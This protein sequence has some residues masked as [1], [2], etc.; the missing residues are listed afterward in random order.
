LQG[1]ANY[2]QSYG[3]GG[4]ATFNTHDGFLEAVI[5][6][7]RKGLLT[8]TDMGVLTQCDSL[9]DLKVYLNNSTDYG[10]SF[11]QNEPSPIHTTTIAEHATRRLVEDFEYLRKNAVEPLSTFLDYITY[12]YM[13][14]NVVLLIS[15]TLHDRDT[16]ELIDKCHPLGRFEA[17]ETITV[18][19]SVAELYRL[20]IIETPL[21]PYFKDT[22]REE[23]LDE[24]NVEIIRNTLY[25]SYLED[26]YLFCQRLG[27]VTGE[28]MCELLKFEADRRSITITIN[29]LGTELNAA[30]RQKLYP[31]FGLL[32]PEGVAALEKAE[33][34]DHVVAA[35]QHVQVYRDLLSSLS[36]QG[37]SRLDAA[38][39]EHEV[40]LNRLAFMEQ[41][42][43]GVF[44]AFV[45]LR[46]QEIRNLVWVAECISQDHRE[47]IGQFIPIF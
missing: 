25:R 16:H 10:E 22:L 31:S 33:E 29:S 23:D 44:Y 8:G 19:Q 11:L 46:E 2:S 24:V 34:Q 6:G 7:Y 32:Y 26:F 35:C 28:V 47:K 42:H 15:G 1:M 40:K 39:F 36:G 18:A 9:E 37:E 17:M 12:G 27:G 30:D 13:I 38:F 20:I 5:R 45:K 41:M 3:V 43:Y 14:D 21:A 4:L